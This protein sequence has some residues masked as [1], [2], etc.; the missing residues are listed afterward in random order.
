MVANSS[1]PELVLNSIQQANANDLPQIGRQFLTSAYLMSNQDT[2]EFTLWA[3]NPTSDENLVAVDSQN[4]VVE[5]FCSATTSSVQSSTPS[6]QSMAM[7]TATNTPTN[8]P[9]GIPDTSSRLSTG[10]IAGTVIGSVAVAAGLAGLLLWFIAKRTRATT[11]LIMHDSCS[12]MTQELQDQPKASPAYVPQELY[13]QSS[14]Q[15]A[16]KPHELP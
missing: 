16:W 3:A 2:D 8:T 14:N 10:A 12:Q 11:G 9:T 5:D 6:A 1:E 7:H 4:Q 13:A 15:D